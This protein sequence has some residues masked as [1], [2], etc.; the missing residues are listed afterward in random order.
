MKKKETLTG[1]EELF[2]SIIEYSLDKNDQFHLLCKTV[3]AGYAYLLA[4]QETPPLGPLNE[5]GIADMIVPEIPNFKQTRMFCQLGFIKRMSNE[6]SE[7]DYN[8]FASW[9]DVVWEFTDRGFRFLCYLKYFVLRENKMLEED[10]VERKK[11]VS[12]PIPRL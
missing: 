1:E 5:R 8:S 3:N 7:N 11:N 4:F 6:M 12:H 10:F 9:D 2:E